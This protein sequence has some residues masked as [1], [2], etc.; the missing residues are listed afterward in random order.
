MALFSR[1]SI[2]LTS[3]IKKRKSD[4]AGLYELKP[5][6]KRLL[7]LVTVKSWMAAPLKW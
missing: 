3:K 6:V 1:V 7:C 2:K 5:I 4:N